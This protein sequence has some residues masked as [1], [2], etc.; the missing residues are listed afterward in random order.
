MSQPGM[1]DQRIAATLVEHIDTVDGIANGCCS[2][3]S[4]GSSFMTGSELM[5]D[6][7]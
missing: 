5:I 6:G 1:H 4:D 7:G 3:A 2:W